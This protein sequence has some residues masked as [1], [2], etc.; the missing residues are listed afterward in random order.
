[1]ILVYHLLVQFK[2]YLIS[3]LC[4][5]YVKKNALN[6]EKKIQIFKLDRREKHIIERANNNKTKLEDKL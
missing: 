5:I 2:V 1:M 4:L 3:H 6:K